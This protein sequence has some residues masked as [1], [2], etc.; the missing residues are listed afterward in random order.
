MASVATELG[1]W[2]PELCF[3]EPSPRVQGPKNVWEKLAIGWGDSFQSAGAG[4]PP[5]KQPQR[6][7]PA[8]LWALLL[9]LALPAPHTGP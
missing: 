3:P 9:T 8:R 6:S 1:V 2:E 5:G 4:P 7:R